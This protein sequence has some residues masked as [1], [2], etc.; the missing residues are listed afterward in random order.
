MKAVLQRVSHA[1]VTVDSDVAGQIDRGLLVY[2]GVS[3]ADGPDQ[4]AKLADKV[5]ALRIFEDD[6]GKMNLSVRDICGR[7]LVVPNFT[8]QADARKGRRP[9]FV[10]AARPAQAEPLF[11]AFV[12]A[13][14]AL[15][16]SVATGV[17]G[18]HMHID[19]QADGPVNIILDIP[20]E[21]DNEKGPDPAPRG[22]TTD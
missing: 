10:N 14:T 17:F 19:S 12:A 5:A 15:G 22:E 11:H 6:A 20:P 9:A 2:V 16:C 13:L 1:R 18:A 3:V 8:L 7:L 4:A 21:G